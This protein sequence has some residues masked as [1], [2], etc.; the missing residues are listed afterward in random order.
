MKG[1]NIRIAYG[2]IEVRRRTKILEV[3]ASQ[4]TNVRLGVFKKE[5]REHGQ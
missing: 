1:V 2:I 4:H 5:E 3:R